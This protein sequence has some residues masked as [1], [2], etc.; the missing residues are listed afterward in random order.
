MEPL[1]NSRALSL[2][3]PALVGLMDCSSWLYSSNRKLAR[4]SK[5]HCSKCHERIPPGKAGRLCAECRKEGK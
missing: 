3:L 5:E 1:S 2:M 4:G